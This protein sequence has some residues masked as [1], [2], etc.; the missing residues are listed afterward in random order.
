MCQSPFD[1]EPFAINK[2]QV[3]NHLERKLENGLIDQNSR[4]MK[5]DALKD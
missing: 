1:L 4:E 2:I 3:T 5:K